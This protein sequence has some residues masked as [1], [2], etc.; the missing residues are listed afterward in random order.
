L[1][2]SGFVAEA[3]GPQL[4]CSRMLTARP[5]LEIRLRRHKCHG[6]LCVLVRF[7]VGVEHCLSYTWNCMCATK[8]CVLGP[9]SMVQPCLAGCQALHCGCHRRVPPATLACA[10]YWRAVCRALPLGRK[11]QT[12][13]QHVQ[14]NCHNVTRPTWTNGQGSWRACIKKGARANPQSTTGA[15]WEL[16][17]VCPMAT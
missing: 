4:G 7:D 15:V 8:L 9:S 11:G 10:L 12:A 17:T 14:Q 13:M 5:G 3:A 1:D 6:V 16:L 2:S